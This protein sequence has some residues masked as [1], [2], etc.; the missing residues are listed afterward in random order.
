MTVY[1]LAPNFGQE[2]SSLSRRAKSQIF[3]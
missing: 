3:S 2:Q 1:L